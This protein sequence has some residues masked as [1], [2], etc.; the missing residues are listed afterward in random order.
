MNLIK[1]H[2][3]RQEMLIEPLNS[4]LITGITNDPVRTIGNVKINIFKNPVEFHV[5]DNELP[6][7]PDGTLGGP[8]LRQ[9]QAQISFRHNTLVTVSNPI[10]PI[11]FVDS[12]SQEANKTLKSEIKSFA[13]ILK[14]KARTRQPIAIDVSD[15]NVR[16][17]YLPRIETP[18]D[19]YI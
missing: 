2:A 13:R 5:V 9:E 10:T 8:Y 14:I 19:I 12:E 11:P 17:G 3:L 15:S 6:I 16:Q 1:L 4:I 7:S 18:E